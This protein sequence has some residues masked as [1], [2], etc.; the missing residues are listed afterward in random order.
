[1]IKDRNPILTIS[2]KE[3][4]KRLESRLDKAT[5]LVESK[6]DSLVELLTVLHDFREWDEYNFKMLRSIFSTPY[7]A[8]EYRKLHLESVIASEAA[9]SSAYYAFEKDIAAVRQN[10]TA[11]ASALES[12]IEKLHLLNSAERIEE[13]KARSEFLHPYGNK[14]F[15]VHLHD[16]AICETVSNLLK[17]KSLDTI[18]HQ[19]NPDGGKRIIEAFNAGER[20][21]ASRF[22]SLRRILSGP[23]CP[24]ASS[25]LKDCGTTWFSDSEMSS[26][27][28]GWIKRACYIAAIPKS[29]SICTG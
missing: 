5:L 11:K 9:V 8:D 15:V 19:V 27:D 20:K 22:L 26:H 13:Q 29:R 6:I 24:S 7:I 12:I 16:D 3:A 18:I 1:M 21:S 28:W 25:H 4:R 23:R 2:S 14:V 10:I 17:E